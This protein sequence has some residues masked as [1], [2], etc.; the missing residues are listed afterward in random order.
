MTTN[1]WVEQV[2]P[3]IKSLLIYLPL[4]MSNFSS[5]F[6]PSKYWYDYK[7]MWE[8]SEYGEVSMLHV[9]SDHIWRPDIS[10]YNK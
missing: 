7:L 5:G 10:L 6:P 4:N 1:L 3:N 8:P 2:L 9:P